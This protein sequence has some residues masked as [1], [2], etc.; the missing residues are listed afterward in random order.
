MTSTKAQTPVR[1]FAHIAAAMWHQSRSFLSAHL[2]L[3]TSDLFA[4]TPTP[5]LAHL[6]TMFEERERYAV[7]DFL[8]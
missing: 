2:G 3:R 5:S 4:Y 8:S 7:R 6:F 1:S